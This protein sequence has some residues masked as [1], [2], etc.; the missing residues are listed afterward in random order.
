MNSPHT[1]TH[2]PYKM[3]APTAY[4]SETRTVPKNCLHLTTVC[5]LNQKLWVHQTVTH[6]A[7]LYHPL[8]NK[9][10]ITTEAMQYTK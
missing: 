8:F 5:S 2:K 7:P 9:K 3:S 4:I 1:Y 10:K 6:Q